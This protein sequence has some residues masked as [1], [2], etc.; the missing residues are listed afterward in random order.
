VAQNGTASVNATI[1]PLMPGTWE[2]AWDLYIDGAGWLSAAPY[3]VC[4]MTIQYVIPNQPPN[5]SL[6]YPANYSTVLTRTPT[7]YASGVDPDQWPG[8][9]LT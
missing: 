9:A 5:L 4:T 6:D 2:V 7:V 8:A 1:D 3:G